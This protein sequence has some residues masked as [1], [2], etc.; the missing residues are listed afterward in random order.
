MRKLLLAG[1]ALI[2][3]ALATPANADYPDQPIRIVVPNAPGGSTDLTARIFQRALEQI[4]PEPVIVANV[5][6]GG[7]SVGAREVKDAAPDG[8]TVLMIHQALMTAAA[9]GVADF[10]PDALVKVAQTGSDPSILVVGKDSPYK[11]LA[12]LF[13]AA[14]QQPD[15]LKAGVQ[16]GA[17]NHISMLAAAKAGGD[18]RFRYVQTGGGGPSLTQLMGGHIDVT[19]LT[20]SDALRYHQSGD[21]RILATFEPERHPAIPD[22]PTAR[23]Q[24]FDV[25]LPIKHIWWMPKETPQD[26]VDAFADALEKAMQMPEVQKHLT[27]SLTSP[28]FMR[29]AELEQE[30]AREYERIQGL[31]AEAGI[32]KK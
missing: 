14:K 23:D 3:A 11:T 25:L 13:T 24:G 27:Q 29:G 8:Y 22:I 20:L 12:D 16:I 30:V 7:T 4:F 26:R 2:G 28:V 31:V 18:V 17:L 6:G 21:V 15:T 19:Y 9:T 5:V 10:G 1:L 32:A